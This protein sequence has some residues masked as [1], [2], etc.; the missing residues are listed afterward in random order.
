MYFYLCPVK[1]HSFVVKCP[2]ESKHRCV[3][4]FSVTQSCPALY[5]PMDYSVPAPL[6]VGFPRQE[7]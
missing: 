2:K 4:A 5:N 1:H 3:Y 6:S 7:H